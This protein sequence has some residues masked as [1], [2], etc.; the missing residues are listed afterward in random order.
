MEFK[1]IEPGN[2]RILECLPDGGIISSENDALD[3][4]GLCGGE[5]T[6]IVLLYH[7]NLHPDFYDLKTGL[8]GK[9]MLKLTNYQI[10]LAAVIP[11][12]LVGTGRFYEMVIETNRR[13]DFRVYGTRDEALQWISKL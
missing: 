1:I 2:K 3:L 9:V 10:H 13:N 4:V 8:A 11:T 6:D 12:G 7:T 5:Q